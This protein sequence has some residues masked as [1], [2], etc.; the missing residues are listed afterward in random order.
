MRIVSLLPSATEIVA[1]LGLAEYLVARSHECD[2]P[3][4]IRKLPACTAKEIE[5]NESTPGIQ[6][7][8]TAPSY[9]TLSV[10]SVD[11][12]LLRGLRPTHI[13]TQS[14]CGACAV[15]EADLAAVLEKELFE[16][17]EVLSLEARTL[18]GVIEEI[19]TVSAFLGEEARGEALAST[20]HARIGR[21][22]ERAAER[23]GDKPVVACLEWLQPFM[24]GGQWI[25]EMIRRAGGIPAGGGDGTGSPWMDWPELIATEADLIVSMPCGWQLP[26]ALKETRRAAERPEWKRL[27]AV[28]RNQVYVVD[29]SDYF[30]RPGPRL[31]DSIEILAEIIA[32]DLFPPQHHPQGW[33]RFP[34]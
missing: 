12:D 14:L 19:R 23:D 20:L 11:W 10:F 16:K 18:S 2:F 3:A 22:A 30:N 8:A 4:G 1:A 27:K 21:I 33:V 9:R 24:L 34:G 17:P 28:G 29:G 6:L 15:S 13:L 25:P 31:V 5:L 7:R 26:R 32:P